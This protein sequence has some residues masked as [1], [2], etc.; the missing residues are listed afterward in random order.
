MAVTEHISSTWPLVPPYSKRPTVYPT[1]HL[2]WVS[3]ITKNLTWV[4]S[5]QFLWGMEVG[6]T[7]PS[8]PETLGNKSQAL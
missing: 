5:N 2:L 4:I 7:S 6:R 1:Q 3:E 8:S